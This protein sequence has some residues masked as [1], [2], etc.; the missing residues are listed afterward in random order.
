M[1]SYVPISLTVPQYMDGN[2]DPADGFVL[3]A[4]DAGTTPGSGTIL[5]LATDSTGSSLQ[6]S[7]ALNS[8]GEPEVSSNTIIPHVNN[9]MQLALYPTQ[10]AADADTGATWTIDNITLPGIAA[11]ATHNEDYTFVLSD[12]GKTIIKTSADTA[13]RTWTIPLNSS[14]AFPVGAIMLLINEDDNDITLT[15]TGAAT[16]KILDGTAPADGDVTI[17]EGGLLTLYMKAAD[18]WLCWGNLG[19]SG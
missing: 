14:V 19:V 1:S 13:A 9:N 18:D 11:P 16:L 7:I 3:K 8:R 6:N 15:A 12:N 17:S 10:A 2:G 5:Q 4:Y